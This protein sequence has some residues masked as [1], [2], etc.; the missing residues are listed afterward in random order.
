MSPYLPVSL[1]HCLIRRTIK[2][3]RRTKQFTK[4]IDCQRQALDT[5]RNV[6][7]RANAGSGKTSVLVERVVQI[8]DQWRQ[9]GKPPALSK[10]VAITF[11]RKAAAE[12][13]VR[14]RKNF[15]ELVRQ[16]SSSAEQAFWNDADRALGQA[17]IGTIDAWCAR[18]LREFH[19]DGDGGDRIEPDFDA[20]DAY[21]AALLRDEAIS[22][23][24]NRHAPNSSAPGNRQD[25]AVAWWSKREGL[26]KLSDHLHRLLWDSV[27]PE[28][29]AAA[30]ESAA[31]AEERCQQIWSEQP[32]VCFLRAHRQELKERLGALCATAGTKP[33]TKTIGEKR[34]CAES[35][36]QVL[37]N[38]KFDEEC[39]NGL[40]RLLLTQKREPS[41]LRSLEPIDGHLDTLQKTWAPLLAEELPDLVG[42]KHAMVAAD[43]LA[44]LLVPVH[45]E[46]LGLCRDANRYDFQTLARFTRDM[47]RD[48]PALRSKL[49]ERYR[50]VMVDEFQDTNPLQWEIIS[51]V[52]GAGP[53]GKLDSDRLFVVGDPQQSIFRFR[54]ADVR[55]FREIEELIKAS[56]RQ[57]GMADKKT[58][59][60]K[61]PGSAPAEEDQ[62]LGFV[63]LAENFRSLSPMPLQLM[64]RV[65]AYVFDPI[66]HKLDPARDRFEIT[67]QPLKKGVTCDTCGEVRYVRLG[68]AQDSDQK[69]DPEDPEASEGPPDKEVLAIDQVEAIAGE[70]ARLKGKPRLIEDPAKA[71]TLE[72]KDM[73][74]LLP[75]RTITLGALEIALRRWRIP[76]VVTGGIGFWQRQE[77]LDLVNLAQW[78][79]DP[80]DELALFTIL[81]SPLAR[82]T[83]TEIFFL[84]CLGRGNLW[85]GL[86]WIGASNGTPPFDVKTSEK[87]GEELSRDEP[88]SQECEALKATWQKFNQERREALGSM[89]GRLDVWLSGVDRLGHADLLRR[90]LEESGAFAFYGVLPEGAQ[91]LANLRQFF[92]WVLLAEHDNALTMNQLARRLRSLVDEADREGQ[93]PLAL[94][95]DAVQITTVHSAKGLQFPVVAVL[96][97]EKGM[98]ADYP[99]LLVV[100]QANE[101]DEVGTI[102]VRVRHPERPLRAFTCQ[103]LRR[104]HNLNRKQM[105]AERRRLFYVAATRASERLLLAG[106]GR[107]K[108]LSPEKTLTWQDWFEDALEIADSDV[109]AGFWQD[110]ARG[111]QVTIINKLDG[112]PAPETG[113]PDEAPAVDLEA[114]DERA[115][116]TF[117]A[118][119][120]VESVRDLSRK[121]PAGTWMRQH[122]H[123]DPSPKAFASDW[124]AVPA[125]RDERAL[126]AV[127]GTLVHRLLAM[128]PGALGTATVDFDRRVAAMA[129][130]LLD[131]GMESDALE[132]ES[133]Q[134]SD[135]DLV[136]ARTKEILGR[137][138]QTDQAAR[139]VCKL[140]AA[141]GLTEVPFLLPLGRWRLRGRFDKLIAAGPDGRC[142]LVDWKT[143]RI[144]HAA[145]HKPQLGIYALALSRAGRASRADGTV[146]AKLVF[147]QSAEIVEMTFSASDLDELAKELER[148]LAKL[149]QSPDVPAGAKRYNSQS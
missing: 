18:I 133:P 15:A 22:R 33:R 37:D 126:G 115:P 66:V 142:I 123:V 55:V 46:Y 86:R 60:E 134:P 49:R 59:F 69:E 117:L 100:D 107:A 35:I 130:A 148:D 72:W 137:L 25:Q 75:T 76:F 92:D 121:D 136:I 47:L 34:A 124:L 116:I 65:F 97:M 113:L 39:L 63:P 50:Y 81:R 64:D 132:T 62:R 119:T 104:L 54:Q 28:V 79:T 29:I 94:D 89:A 43:H 93:A 53:A 1:S 58:D 67:Y 143:D 103:G 48:S 122:L 71:P 147:L 118:A 138:R 91:I 85:R 73:A 61:L 32:A 38:P 127:V 105:I 131:A 41:S 7:V 141:P 4:F 44:C 74:I 82:L 57:N 20:L 68:T 52:V 125:E 140:L 40:C 120:K 139:N 21:E 45:K 16:V 5:S 114:I 31:P 70:L 51:W 24:I 101:S 2:P 106:T 56:N 144:G 77:I 109:D 42:E 99:E 112:A 80:G 23:V 78:L 135:V 90:A 9:E 110:A 146:D 6:L 30:H 87:T 129:T 95:Q 98:R 128:G 12:L 36:L 17:M 8:L 83:D 19:W 111:F 13:Q 14:L 10:L 145:D 108:K 84:S 149:D 27:D 88:S 102:C 96:Q 11:T 26:T 3:M